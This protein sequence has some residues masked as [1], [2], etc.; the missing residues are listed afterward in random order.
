M[1]KE[2]KI[3]ARC[4]EDLPFSEYTP[5]RDGYTKVIAYCRSCARARYHEDVKHRPEHK[6]YMEAYRYRKYGISQEIYDEMYLRQKGRCSICGRIP[7][8]KLYVDHDHATGSVRGLLCN[9][10]NV[11]L[12]LLDNEDLLEKALNYLWRP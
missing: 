12:H 6:K 10:C 5:R 2:S 1:I 3:C 9:R 7:P 4:K 11:S 8:K